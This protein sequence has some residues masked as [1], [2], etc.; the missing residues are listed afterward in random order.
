MTI[1]KL[2][3][4]SDLCNLQQLERKEKLV[5]VPEAKR[6]DFEQRKISF[7]PG[8]NLPIFKSLSMNIGESRDLRLL[9]IVGVRLHK[10]SF[11]A[12]GKAVAKSKSL[13]KL[14]ISQTNIASCGL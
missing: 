4:W 2:S 6:Q 3:L 12:L 10:D 11:A 14:L 5:E 1:Q 8:D 7:N 9:Q 13:K